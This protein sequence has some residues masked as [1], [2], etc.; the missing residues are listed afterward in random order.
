[1]VYETTFLE[2]EYVSFEKLY[3][4]YI[5]CRKRKTSA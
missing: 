3:E 4:A 1:M 5:D 2:N